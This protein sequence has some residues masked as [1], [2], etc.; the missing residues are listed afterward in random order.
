MSIF[1]LADNRKQSLSQNSQNKQN[2]FRDSL[3]Y[4]RTKRLTSSPVIFH[5]LS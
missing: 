4:L 1:R 3:K 2:I 5:Y